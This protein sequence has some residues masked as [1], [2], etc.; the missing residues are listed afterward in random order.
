MND[1]DNLLRTYHIL[2]DHWQERLDIHVKDSCWTITSAETGASI[3][4][5]DRDIPAII[6]ALQE[7]LQHPEATEV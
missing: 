7:I 5:L 4:L 6:A 3:S 2:R 1:P